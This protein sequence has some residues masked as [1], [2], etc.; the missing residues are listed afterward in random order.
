MGSVAGESRQSARA[1]GSESQRQSRQR[2]ADATAKKKLSYLEAREF[3]AIEQRIAQ[4]E[5][6][7]Q[8]KRAAAEDPNIASDATACFRPMPRWIRHRKQSTSCIAAGPSWKRSRAKCAPARVTMLG[9]VAALVIVGLQHNSS[10][11]TIKTR[12]IA[13]LLF[14]MHRQPAGKSVR[15]SEISNFCLHRDC[16]RRPYFSSRLSNTF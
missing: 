6:V 1:A 13:R 4:A 14:Q 9:D 8:E 12:A 15:R 16:Y 5:N 10:R 2:A 7:L 11:E 3:A